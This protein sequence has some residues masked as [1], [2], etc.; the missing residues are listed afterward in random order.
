MI[1]DGNTINS[2]DK[3]PCDICILGA[4][5]AG[6]T[7]ARELESLNLKTVLIESGGTEPQPQ[8]QELYKGKISGL[9]YDLAGSRS[10]FF[11]GSTNCWVGLIAELD[12]IDF[13]RRSSIP[14]SGWPITKED[15]QSHYLKARDMLD[16]GDY[17]DFPFALPNQSGTMP[18]SSDKP[19]YISEKIVTKRYDIRPKRFLEFYSELGL[20]KNTQVFLN[21]NA[22]DLIPGEFVK[23]ISSVKIRTLGGKEFSILPKKVIV[24][25]GGIET[26]RLLLA[27]N[28]VAQNGI[29]N[30][31]NLVGRFFM[32]HPH[33]DN[34]ANL[35]SFTSG[36]EYHLPDFK[37]LFYT[38]FSVAEEVKEKEGLLNA[39]MFILTNSSLESDST[40]RGIS[41]LNRN[42][43]KI[44]PQSLYRIG[45]PC[46]QSPNPDSR[47]TLTQERDALGMPVVNLDWKLAS[48]DIESLHRSNEIFGHEIGASGLGRYQIQFQKD[49]VFEEVTGGNHHMGTTRMASSPD[50][51]VVD[52]HCKVFGMANLYVAGSSVFP[53]GG[54]ANPTLT[55]LA[56]A[57]RLADHIKDTYA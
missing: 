6:I 56:L 44:T 32:E 57:Y 40:G 4:G 52:R 26:P 34:K 37:Q 38:A 55:I 12:A 50:Q 47:V 8:T 25:L 7:I 3:F 28:S 39:A 33:I 31:Q 29:G 43:F 22:V 18:N 13:K 46:E 45:N 15:L 24:A 48:F 16:S 9:N 11:G 36:F 2:G 19:L 35:L 23:Q 27:S 30:D 1:I 20:S 17:S 21:S 5:A 54:A 53:T 41:E 51:G 14:Y 10:R 49:E 42:A